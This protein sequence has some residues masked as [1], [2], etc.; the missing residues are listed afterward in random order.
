MRDRKTSDQGAFAN[1][2]L[3]EAFDDALQQKPYKVVEV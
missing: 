2:T 1:Q 3:M